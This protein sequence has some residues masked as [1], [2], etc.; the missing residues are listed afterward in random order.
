MTFLQGFK[1]E[2][3][4]LLTNFAEH[5]SAHW[6]HLAAQVTAGNKSRQNNS[7]GNWGLFWYWLKASHK[8]KPSHCRCSYSTPL[9]SSCAHLLL[10]SS[11]GQTDRLLLGSG[12]EASCLH[13]SCSRRLPRGDGGRPRASCLPRTQTN[14]LPVPSKRLVFLSQW[15]GFCPF[16]PEY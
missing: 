7:P 2:F 14:G 15:T 4:H 8:I 10:P 1:R 6:Q 3:A 11:L 13:Q 5:Q 12:A 16:I 9:V